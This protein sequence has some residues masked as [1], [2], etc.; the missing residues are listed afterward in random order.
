ML[1]VALITLVIMPHIN[2]KNLHE[3]AHITLVITP[4]IN[5]KRHFNWHT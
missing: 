4:Q 3:L 1:D 2:K 5:T